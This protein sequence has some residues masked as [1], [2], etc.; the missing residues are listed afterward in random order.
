MATIFFIPVLLQ[1]LAMVADEIWFHHRREL[2]RWERIGHPLDTLTIVLCLGW[3]LAGGGLHV[4]I[5]LAIA[6]TLFVTKDE[7]V[8]AKLCG[9]GEQWLHALLFA[10]HPVV[11]A[12]FGYLSYKGQTGIL[13]GQLFVTIAFMTYQFVYWN[14]PTKAKVINNE[15]YADLGERWY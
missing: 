13:T 8:H 11:L 5:A 4:Y 10:L 1:A 6:S 7:A 12:A 14:R 15:W 2:P 9:A 3:L